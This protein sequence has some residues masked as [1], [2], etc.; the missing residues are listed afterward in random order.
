MPSERW[1]PAHNLQRREPVLTPRGRSNQ[2]ALEQ[3]L[4]ALAA[5]VWGAV[6][7]LRMQPRIRPAAG[8][9]GTVRC[10]RCTR[11]PVPL[12]RAAAQVGQL[13]GIGCAA[14][15]HRGHAGLRSSASGPS[16]SKRKVLTTPP[17]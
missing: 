17:G 7:A 3:L 14:Q 12:E 11:L 10:W 5:S 15:R 13:C 9:G 4:G 6:P 8:A 2:V 16:V 1:L